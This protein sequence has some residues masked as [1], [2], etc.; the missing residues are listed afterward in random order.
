MKRTDIILSTITLAMAFASPALAQRQQA[1]GPGITPLSPT[2]SLGGVDMSASGTTGT[3]S[4]GV[5]GGP[6]TDIL[7]GNNPFVAGPL[8]VS[9][10]VSSQGNIVF[11]S[12]ST[13][14]GDIGVTQPGG[15]FL[16]AV[17]G[18]NTGT[19]VSLLGS[20]YATTLN[21]TGTGTVAF[22]SGGINIT[23]T[24]FA[25]DGTITLAPNTTVIGALTTT[26]GAD[27][28]SLVLGGASVLNGAVGGAVGLRSI[29][30]QGN[31]VVA[32]ITGATS[33]YGLSLGTNTLNIG[34]ALTLA[35]GGPAGVINTTLASPSVYGNVR[36]VGATI[37]GASL[38]VNATVPNT[39]VI[40]VGT[41]FNIVQ[42]QAGTQQSGT[43]GSV[44]TVTVQDPTNPL[45][46]FAATP[47]A[48]TVAGQVTI[49]T[50]SVPLLVVV[51]P[52]VGVPLPPSLPV[53]APIAPVLAGLVAVSA[54]AADILSVIAPINALTNAGDVVNAVAQLSPSTASQAAPLAAFR[55]A[56][57]FEGLWQ[58]RLETVLCNDT[59]RKQPDTARTCDLQAPQSNWWM[60]GFAYGGSQ[61]A[62]QSFA[63]YD[64]TILGTMIGY[65][66]PVGLNT[67]VGVGIGF[68][69]TR[70]TQA[71][72]SSRTTFQTYQASLYAGHRDGPWS[73][74][75]D[76][77]VGLNDYSGT[78]QI[79]FPGVSRLAG[80]TGGGQSYSA[81]LRT[82]YDIA[83]GNVTI[84]PMASL[85]YSN[86][87]VDGYHETGAG[88]INLRVNAQAYD[89][90]QSGL[91]VRIEREYT[92]DFGA[93]VPELHAK[94]L[95]ELNNPVLKQT[96]SFTAAGSSSFTTPGL[97]GPADTLDAG[98]GLTL[99]SCTCGLRSW[100]VE[101][102]YDYFRGSNNYQAHQGMIK[103]TAHF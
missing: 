29:A 94:W 8:A 85:Q 81:S 17:S 64:T 60:R 43:N 58:S 103:L 28:G 91:G 57:L 47:L 44:V 3:L 7:T 16:L 78:R 13:V 74:S 79:A 36:P 54:P 12:G 99:Y 53:A 52:P 42:T 75:G 22:N 50:L 102:G 96:A 45:Y 55:T 69:D 31:G 89:F 49:R 6:A 76:A 19:T 26:A 86:I 88:D 11:N 18:G 97:T 32:T 9:T 34:G 93:V 82:G 39:A 37:L 72:S 65:D 101:A 100:S 95:H 23:A 51:T 59:R 20:L 70:V 38:R 21:V 98:V 4:V 35:N 27:T 73:V 25:A 41:Q 48:G 67:R 56:G 87:H 15:P 83:A 84:T 90:L 77:S 62:R 46:T 2:G 30:V 1:V 61:G 24:N 80:S 10:A 68:A 33:T 14:Y 40:P 63:A 71:G 5:P 92:A 66:R